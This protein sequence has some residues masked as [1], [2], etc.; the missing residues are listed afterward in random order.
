M[1]DLHKTLNRSPRN[2]K[3]L[4]DCPGP[5][6]KETTCLGIVRQETTL[7][8]DKIGGCQNLLALRG[9]F[10]DLEGSHRTFIRYL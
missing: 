10:S 1:G 7:F 3:L 2:K 8:P 6:P 5:G 9:P 4:A